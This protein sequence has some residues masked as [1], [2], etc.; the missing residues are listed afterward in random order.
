MGPTPEGGEIDFDDR[1]G[2]G[3]GDGGGPER[4]YWP[5]DASLPGKYSFGV[6]YYSGDG[7]A[8]YALRVYKGETLVMTKTG[9]LSSVGGEIFVGSL[10]D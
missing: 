9:S 3:E 2:S 4:V 10:E 7:T 8:N 1:G 5:L 6:R